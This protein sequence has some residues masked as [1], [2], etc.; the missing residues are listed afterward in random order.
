MSDFATEKKRAGVRGLESRM[1]LG[2]KQSEKEVEMPRR[3]NPL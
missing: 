2:N 3:E 1:S